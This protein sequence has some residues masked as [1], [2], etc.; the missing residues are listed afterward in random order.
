MASEAVANAESFFC[1]LGTSKMSAQERV[2]YELKI[3]RES[4]LRKANEYARA[5]NRIERYRLECSERLE[6][7]HNGHDLH[8]RRF[9]DKQK[10]QA[11]AHEREMAKLNAEFP[12]GAARE[13]LRA[14]NVE[15]TKAVAALHRFRVDHLKEG[16]RFSTFK[17][18]WRRELI[19]RFDES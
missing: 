3:E 14:I 10:R 16:E 8:G 15:I 19:G 17:I 5:L 12:L 7:R 1:D 18:N 6:T 4:L 13:E 9:R 2:V 11:A